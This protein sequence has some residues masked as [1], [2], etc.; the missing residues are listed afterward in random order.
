MLA[1]KLELRRHQRK[2][3]YRVT[4]EQNDDQRRKNAV[5][6]AFVEIKKTKIT[7]LKAFK[8]NA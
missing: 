4:G 6:P 5:N 8:N 2:P 1:Q 7:G 3:T